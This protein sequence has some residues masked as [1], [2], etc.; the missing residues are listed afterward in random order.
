[1]TLFV[2]LIQYTF[3]VSGLCLGAELVW[4]GVVVFGFFGFVLS[5]L[6]WGPLILVA[7]GFCEVWCGFPVLFLLV[8]GFRV[9]VAGLP[10]GWFAGSFV[11]WGCC[12]VGWALGIFLGFY[13][14]CGVDII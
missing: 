6:G 11:V 9:I 7:G 12:G 1:M 4:L 13:V 2:G 3:L 10:T 14:S 5:G 8:S